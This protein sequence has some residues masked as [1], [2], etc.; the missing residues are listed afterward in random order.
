M[1]AEVNWDW[2]FINVLWV[3]EELRGQGDGKSPLMHVEEEAQ[4]WGAKNSY[5]DTFSFQA[6]EFYKRNGYHVF[7]EL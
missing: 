1:I 2:L 5:L 4:Q 7:G 3:K 6:P